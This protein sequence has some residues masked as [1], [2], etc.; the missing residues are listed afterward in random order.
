IGTSGVAKRVCANSPDSSAAAFAFDLD[1]AAA[2][3]RLL[4]R[5]LG[6]ATPGRVLGPLFD[7]SPMLIGRLALGGRG[8]PGITTIVALSV[9]PAPSAVILKV[10]VTIA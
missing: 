3:F 2:F 10:P 1:V 9:L 6:A 7:V 4:W 5:P 8:G